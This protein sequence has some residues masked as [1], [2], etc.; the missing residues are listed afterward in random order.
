[1]S[2]LPERDPGISHVELAPFLQPP[3]GEALELARC[4]GDALGAQPLGLI[5]R[6]EAPGDEMF[7]HTLYASTRADEM[8]RVD[9]PEDRKQAFLLQQSIAQIRHYRQHYPTAAFLM[10]RHGSEWV[11]RIYLDAGR[12]E[13][14]LMDIAVLPIHRGIGLGR[15]LMAAVV[16]IARDLRLS[17][18]LH[19]EPEN[20]VRAWYGRLGF[21]Q[22]GTA[23][24]YHLMRL[25]CEALAAAQEKLI[26]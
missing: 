9:W 23:G 10:C 11:G 13:L 15:V 20:R 7:L 24:Y 1:M 19:V 26:A 21:E 25:P 5:V 3:A 17:V 22:K 18:S 8:A 12:E 4:Y 6:P 16:T 14:R 2:L